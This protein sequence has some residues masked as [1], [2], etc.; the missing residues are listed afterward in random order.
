MLGFLYFYY[1]L[2]NPLQLEEASYKLS[3]LSRYVLYHLLSE[4]CE[5]AGHCEIML[6]SNNVWAFCYTCFI[7][8]LFLIKYMLDDILFKLTIYVLW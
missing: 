6:M 8:W 3:M 7:V 2:S 1:L 5:Y 4:F